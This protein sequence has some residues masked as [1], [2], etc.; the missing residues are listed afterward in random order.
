MKAKVHI[1][2]AN[3]VNLDLLGKREPAI[4]G[5]KGLAD[6]ENYMIQH[7]DGLARITDR[8]GVDLSF[9]Q[10]NDEAAFFDQLAQPFDGAVINPGAWT[11]TSLALADRLAGLALP[12]V[13]VHLSSLAQ[14]EKIRQTSLTA[15]HA[16]GVVYGLGFD[17]YLAGLLGLLCRLP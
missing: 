6:L 10:S 5:T 11:H 15:A 17:S 8:A 16:L 14:R 3:G 7:K 12:F 2:I 1:L 9:F 13:E 4:Y